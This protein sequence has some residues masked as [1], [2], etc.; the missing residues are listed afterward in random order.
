[1]LANVNSIATSTPLL[2]SSNLR[3]EVI[4]GLS[5]AKNFKSTSN[6]EFYIQTATFKRAKNAEHYKN[7][8]IKKYHYPAFVKPQGNY[9]V[10]F[11]GPIPSAA[12]VRALN[13]SGKR[14]VLVKQEQ[15]D[16]HPMF[17]GDKDGVLAP[18]KGPNHFEVI[19]AVGIANLMAGDGYLGVTSSETDRLVQTNRNDWSTFTGQ[20]GIGYVYYLNGAQQYSENTQWFPWIEPELNG[21]YLA[22]NSITGDVWRF[23]S[24]AFNDMTYNMPIEST[25]LMF[26]TALTVVSKKQYSLYAIGGIG[27]AWNRVGYS[28][29]DNNGIPCA[30]QFLNL[31]ATTRSN[32]A[33]EAGAGLSYALNN[34]FSL[35]LEYL[36]TDLGT[37]K[38]PDSGF[39]GTITAPILVPAEFR[40]TTQAALLGLHI[41]I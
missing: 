10:V 3:G 15:Q 18:V 40:L 17:I 20:L 8:L 34:R 39:T 32:F 5:N 9:H 27:N 37:V 30:D 25:R 11:I 6:G 26:D 13:S 33:W 22:R 28:D 21:Y 19:G 12:E 36:Y 7:D 24:P 23:G 41:A 16:K 2:N 1:M 35:S 38:T 4:Y 31:G 14:T 29:K